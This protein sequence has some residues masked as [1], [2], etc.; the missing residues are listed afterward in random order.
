MSWSE[1]WSWKNR[2]CRIKPLKSPQRQKKKKKKGKRHFPRGPVFHKKQLP[3]GSPE[4]LW[5]FRVL[6]VEKSSFTLRKV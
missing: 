1:I 5:L 6:G 3:Q 2:T 4:G